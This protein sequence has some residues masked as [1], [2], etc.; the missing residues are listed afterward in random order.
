MF[1]ENIAYNRYPKV[2]QT[3]NFFPCG[4]VPAFDSWLS[5]I[6]WLVSIVCSL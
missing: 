6:L 1:S 2:T 5:P 4:Y 3:H